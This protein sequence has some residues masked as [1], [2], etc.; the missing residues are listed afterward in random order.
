LPDL[1]QRGR[2][3]GKIAKVALQIDRIRGHFGRRF[4]AYPLLGSRRYR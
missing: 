3:L 1:G 2:A 4:T